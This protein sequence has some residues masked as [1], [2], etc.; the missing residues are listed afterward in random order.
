MQKKF[1]FGMLGQKIGMTRIFNADGSATPVTVVLV[2]E[3]YV[4]QLK[5]NNIDG[6][7]AV[8]IGFGKA[9]INNVNKPN[10]GH[11]SKVGVEPSRML[12]EFRLN[13]DQELDKFT[14]GN[15]IEIDA[16]FSEG[17]FVDV[18]GKS[19]G[20]GFA[21]VIERWNF[22]SNRASHG[23]SRSHNTPGSIGQRQDPGRVF[24]G[25][26]MAGRL[27]GVNVTIQ[28]LQIIKIDKDK[29]VLMIKGA[30]PG[31]NNEKIVVLPSAKIAQ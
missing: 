7:S 23:N 31:A 14:V 6:Y 1:F 18:S 26:K 21:G 27:G 5:K 13:N 10:R 15:K 3:N 11:F 25:K 29:G 22:S 28:N 8:Q 19:K 4:I 24:P 20:H 9:K 2:D 16:V 17:Q 30:I 12:C